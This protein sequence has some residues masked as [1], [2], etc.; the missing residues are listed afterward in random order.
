M[1]LLF[2]FMEDKMLIIEFQGEK[3]WA[4]KKLIDPEELFSKGNMVP[5]YSYTQDV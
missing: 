4:F 1:L 3:T 2:S 5:I